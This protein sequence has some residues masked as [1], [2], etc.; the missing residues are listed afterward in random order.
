[1]YA[2]RR[3]IPM[4]VTVWMEKD[5]KVRKATASSGLMP[6]NTRYNVF[7]SRKFFSNMLNLSSERYHQ[8]SRFD[9]DR[10]MFLKTQRH[11]AEKTMPGLL[12]YVIY[13]YIFFSI[14]LFI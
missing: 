3:T 6:D 2:K 11:K 1:M 5:V 10:K 12:P 8:I 9:Y 4:A 7:L 13:L 14:N